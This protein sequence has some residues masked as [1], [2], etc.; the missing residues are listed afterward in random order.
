MSVRKR[1][2]KSPNGEIKSVWVMDY[3]NTEGR[4]HLQTFQSENEAR[5]RHEFLKL[6]KIRRVELIDYGE[7]E[8]NALA[9][10]GCAIEGMTHEQRQRAFLWLRDK[11]LTAW[12]PC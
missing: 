6:H 3:T 2:W 4:R 7:P 11:Y 12:P 8:L 5:E 9:M 1:K 10:A